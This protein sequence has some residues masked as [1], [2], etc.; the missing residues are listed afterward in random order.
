M[1]QQQFGA[2]YL[3]VGLAAMAAAYLFHLCCNHPFLDGN[4]RTA[5]MA[6]FVFLDANGHDLTASEAELERIVLQVAAGTLS[7]EELTDWLR[8]HSRPRR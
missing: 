1:P 5:A 3:H 4:K 7:K 2:K 6:A 8:D